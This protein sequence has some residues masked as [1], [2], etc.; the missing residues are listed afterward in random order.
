VLPDEAL[1]TLWL[2]AVA[3]YD[4]SANPSPEFAS[5]AAVRTAL[6]ASPLVDASAFDVVVV[7]V[8]GRAMHERGD[9][10]L[11]DYPQARPAGQRAQRKSGSRLPSPPGC[12]ADAA[13]PARSLWR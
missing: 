5:V 3:A 1:E 7:A 10:T 4:S 12:G 8:A 9:K 2:S 13:R 11:L 6:S